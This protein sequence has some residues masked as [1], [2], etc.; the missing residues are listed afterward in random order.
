[1]TGAAA[2]A[3]L[4][5]LLLRPP[6]PASHLRF[7]L[8]FLSFSPSLLRRGGREAA[9]ATRRWRPL[10]AVRR[11]G[12]GSVAALSPT[13]SVRAPQRHLPL[14]SLCSFARRNPRCLCGGGSDGEARRLD[15]AVTR[16]LLLLLYPMAPPTDPL[17]L[18][19][20]GAADPHNNF[21]GN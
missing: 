18:A 8:P 4:L 5:V 17:S 20:F 2:V 15:L 21:Y 16:P 9:P 19:F 6:S 11:C 1:M 12:W 7:S 14:G 13:S 10:R 3:T